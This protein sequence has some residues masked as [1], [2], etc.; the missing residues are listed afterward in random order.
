MITRPILWLLS[1]LVLNGFPLLAQD[2]NDEIK[3]TVN[4]TVDN[5]PKYILVEGAGFLPRK[6]NQATFVVRAK[7]GYQPPAIRISKFIK[8]PFGMGGRFKPMTQPIYLHQDQVSIHVYNDG[9]LSARIEPEW[10]NQALYNELFSGNNEDKKDLIEQNIQS[11]FGFDALYRY[12]N[13]FSNEELAQLLEKT[14]IQDQRELGIIKALMKSRELSQP[15][16]GDTF[17][18]FTLPTANNEEYLIGEPEKSFQLIAF[19]SS[20]CP[21]S[22]QSIPKLAA[23]HAKHADK[24]ELVNVWLDS[25]EE[26]W[27]N[28]ASDTKQMINWPD[29]WDKYKFAQEILNIDSYPKFYLLDSEGRIIDIYRGSRSFDNKTEKILNKSLAEVKQ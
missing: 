18:S 5:P 17:L 16:L 12:R 20:G 7:K 23:L 21:Y 4:L 22:L 26:T 24:L 14:S 29:T 9:K 28:Y 6:A 13:L 19:L 10:E 2:Q 27:K 15:E 3:I 25:S 11:S 1:L 8:Q